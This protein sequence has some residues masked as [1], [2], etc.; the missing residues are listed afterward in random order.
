METIRTKLRTGPDGM[1]TVQV[2]S[3]LPDTDVE[4]IVVVQPLGTNGPAR[5]STPD[6]W[7]QFV[8]ATAG[9]WQ[10]EPLARP[11]QGAFEAR[12]EWA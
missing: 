2:P 9:A 11:T 12:G 8:K 4:V 6:E 7:K 10:G 3:G 1:L 5:T